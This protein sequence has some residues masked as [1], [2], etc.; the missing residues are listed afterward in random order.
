M[1]ILL[2]FDKFKGSL[3][4]ME[5]CAAL[6]EGLRQADAKAELTSCPIADGGEG[7]TEAMVAA[8]GGEWR[9]CPAVDA[10]GRKIKARYGLCESGEDLIAVMEMAEASGM[11]RIAEGDRDILRA[12]TAGTGQMIRHAS[13]KSEVDEI[14]IGIGG[15]ATNDGGAGM[16]AALGIAF[17]DKRGDE[18]E[19]TPG[20]LAKV[21][22]VR[23]AGR[24]RLPRIKVACD[25]ENPLLGEQ[26]ATAIYGPQKGAGPK[27]QKKLEKMLENLVE[28]S[29]SQEVAE[30]P[31]AGAAGG[32][33]FG[34][35][36]FAKAQLVPGF[37]MVAEALDLEEKI[38]RADVVVTGEGSLDAQSLQGKG[39]VGVAKMAKEA[40]AVVVGVAGRITPEVRESGIFK[41]LGTLEQFNLP[42]EESMRRGAE[43][44][45]LTGKRLAG[46]LAG[47]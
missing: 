32:L 19:P 36:Q 11:W 15:S 38:A 40:G 35:M 46:L 14:L 3:S 1:R 33:G 4:A 17:W 20:G 47:D 18:L 28:A 37:E 43:L 44:L 12:T 16:A 10:L 5:A 2:A 39:P 34:L 27:E 24:C 8:M 21:A 7:F 29:E 9:E 26:G 41:H 30:T 23:D 45:Q 6:A 13:L 22:E 42:L 31:G 25:V